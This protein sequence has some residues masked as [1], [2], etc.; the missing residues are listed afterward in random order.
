MIGGLWQLT[1]G[2]GLGLFSNALPGHPAWAGHNRQAVALTDLGNSG[3]EISSYRASLS[4]VPLDREVGGSVAELLKNRRQDFQVATKVYVGK[5]K[6]VFLQ[7]FSIDTTSRADRGICLAAIEL[8]ADILAEE[9]VLRAMLIG[10]ICND[11]DLRGPELR[12]GRTTNS[13][14][15][16]EVML[17][18]AVVEGGSPWSVT[19]LDPSVPPLKH[20]KESRDWL[21]CSAQTPAQLSGNWKQP[22]ALLRGFTFAFDPDGF[23]S[24]TSSESSLRRNNYLYRYLLRAFGGEHPLVE[25]GLSHGLHPRG[26]MRDASQPSA[27]LLNA[28]LIGLDISAPVYDIPRTT[29]D[30]NLLP[31]DG[32]IRWAIATPL[33]EVPSCSPH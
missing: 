9:V 1:V 24:A 19:M 8:G 32:S 15:A 7:G 31:E 2:A 5:N 12:H 33:A 6:S 11:F 20:D 25:G 18:F 3:L 14:A 10:G 16:V 4:V 26:P 17:D 13:E 30:P 22:T 29:P 21:H 28:E 27:L 23:V